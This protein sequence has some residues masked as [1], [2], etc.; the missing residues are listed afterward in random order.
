[1]MLTR[2]WA[3][4]LLFVV[5]GCAP[6]VE[7]DPSKAPPS[8]ATMTVETGDG[9]SVLHVTGSGPL[10]SN[11]LLL[12]GDGLRL[13]PEDLEALKAERI[14]VDNPRRRVLDL[15]DV[16][17]YSLPVFGDLTYARADFRYNGTL[18][19]LEIIPP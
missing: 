16:I 8:I 12:S 15:G 17:S 2:L 13:R 4:L 14:P 3:V 7:P 11:L 18:Y 5:I 1:M 10:L 6:A 9:Y 19:Y